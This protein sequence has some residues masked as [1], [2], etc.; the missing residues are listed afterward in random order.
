MQIST[1]AATT[2]LA[3]KEQYDESTLISLIL[4]NAG[5]TNGV[6]FRN[7]D[8]VLITPTLDR[9]LFTIPYFFLA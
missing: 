3:I 8:Y 9:G 7:Q 2:R 1:P 6:H 4:S 5:L